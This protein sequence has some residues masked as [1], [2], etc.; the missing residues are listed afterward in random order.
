MLKFKK[1]L[2]GSG[3]M[4]LAVAGLLTGCGL[5][6]GEL[7]IADKA[8]G[9]HYEILI[10]PRPTQSAKEGSLEL[11]RLIKK[12]TGVELPVIQTAATPGKK[13]IVIGAHPLAAAAGVDTAGVTADGFKMRVVN[14]NIYLL[15]DDLDKGAFYALG[16]SE[17][18]HAGSYFAVNEF[19]KRYLKA[20]WYMPGP[21]GEDVAV[22]DKLAIPDNL[23]ETIN[24]RFAIRSINNMFY[25]DGTDRY[26]KRLQTMGTF[27][28]YHFD[29][30]AAEEAVRWGRRL[31]NGSDFNFEV[32]HAWFQWVPAQKPNSYTPHAYGKEHPEYFAMQAGLR[33]NYYRGEAHGGQLCISNPDVAK[34]YA[35]N[36]A[37]YSKRTGQKSFSL[38]AND[39]GEHCEC[40]KCASLDV[41]KDYNGETIL[42]DRLAWFSN[43]IAEQ[44]IKSVPDLQFGMYAYHDTR[45]PP[46]KI[47][48]H[49]SIVVSD[50][51]NYLPILYYSPAPQKMME[52]DIRGWRTQSGKVVLTTYYTGE[53]FWGMPWSTIGV[54]SWMIKMLAEYPSSAGLRMCYTGPGDV[55][56][57]GLLGPD[58]WVL[59]QLMW[60]PSLPLEQLENEF[61]A[62]A[63]GPESGKFIREYFN[64]INQ[65]V[66]KAIKA[67][68]IKDRHFYAQITNCIIPTYAGIRPQ[69]AELIAK[70][71][72][73]AADKD[74]RCRWR[75]DRIARGWKLV[76][77]TL[78]SVNA[79]NIAR[80]ATASEKSKAWEQAVALGKERI[81]F[82]DSPDS[83][84]AGA[85]WAMDLYDL[86]CPLG[87][88]AKVPASE[89]QNLTVPM[90]NDAVTFDGKLDESAWQKAG[91]TSSFKENSKG[92]SPAASSRAYLFYSR[93]GLFVGINCREPFMEQ[94]KVNMKPE[95]MWNGDVAEVF[96][97]PAPQMDSHVQFSVNP[98]GLG[99]AV[100]KRGDRGSD[101]NWNPAWKY[102][103]FKGKDFWSVEIFI[104]WECLDLKEMPSPDT[105]WLA[106]FFRERYTGKSENS[107]W[108]PTGSGFAQP[109]M[110]GK[111]K[112]AK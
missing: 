109:L 80:N 74:E 41:R 64:V 60:D 59:S 35:D 55:P 71:V 61:Y 100:I 31:R 111:I 67:R 110:F 49:P 34:I 53:G 68:N 72:A 19:A 33:H 65:A 101:M 28:G 40:P 86:I 79:A 107:G 24:P 54:Q 15:G 76:E 57:M 2:S 29:K 82:A 96:L 92:G 23:N 30:T 56:P 42:T 93:Q 73:A 5:A 39:G 14:G 70:A 91:I 94:L 106:D 1:S 69:C 62:G 6:A 81:A 89:S 22:L 108:S 52:Q 63:F 3:R 21:M 45:V 37:A 7:E 98:G 13:Q 8:K 12:A 84:F 90:I 38:S 36:V 83:R 27:S 17:S 66:S 75:V 104:P 78:D 102:A 11:Q 4:L 16:N 46:S 88:V 43:N 50:V 18:A 51:Y 44:A 87:S 99:K 95:T 105:S 112:F 9:S 10:S 77:L 48:L 25:H 26:L 103:A 47:K 20:R 58:P 97:L 32:S 85:P